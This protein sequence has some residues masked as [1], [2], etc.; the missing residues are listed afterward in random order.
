MPRI[1]KTHTNS[2]LKALC[3]A[4][5]LA[6]SGAAASQAAEAESAPTY[7]AMQGDPDIGAGLH[8][9]NCTSCHGDEIYSR[10]G[11]RVDNLARLDRQLLLCNQQ[12]GLQLFDDELA[13]IAAYLNQNYYRFE[14]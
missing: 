7:G 11:R 8:M 2:T 13:H 14:Q 1:R 9:D 5:L 10:E 3:A 6:L 4:A 12:I